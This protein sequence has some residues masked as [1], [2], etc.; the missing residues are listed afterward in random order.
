MNKE[1]ATPVQIVVLILC[2]LI[3]VGFMLFSF[4]HSRDIQE[5]MKAL[6]IA[7]SGAPNAQ[8]AVHQ[9]RELYGKAQKVNSGIVSQ[10]QVVLSTVMVIT[11]KKRGFIAAVI[12]NVACVVST[13]PGLSHGSTEAISGAIVPVLAIGTMAIIYNYIK[14]N[15]KA[16]ERLNRSFE[17]LMEKNHQIQAA[18][19]Q[20]REL[21]Y[22]DAMT[23]MNNRAWMR[24]T[25]AD[26][27]QE[28]VPFAFIMMDMDN[29]K[30]IN[31][32]FGHE[33][34]DTL[35][36]TYATRFQKYCG[37]K[38]PCAKMGGD[39]FA[40]IIGGAVTQ[41]D[42]LN[43]VAQLQSLFG[44]IVNVNGQQFR[45]TMSYGIAG[46]PNDGQNPDS[47]INAAD[48]ALYNAKIQGKDRPILYSPQSLG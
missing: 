46:S 6:R 24:E 20:L 21:A 36:K 26:K 19:I 30:Q 44:E 31:D 15:D 45:I 37:T 34:G 16:T 33:I 39:E 32:T 11:N 5:F 7:E 27:I 13:I 1:K 23:G 22:S 17:E 29:F 35:I 41:A 48:T 8:E 40:L 2:I 9:L 47:L 4:N 43:I 38:Y 3:F 18:E 12:L 14:N 28:G 25:L 10:L 42:V